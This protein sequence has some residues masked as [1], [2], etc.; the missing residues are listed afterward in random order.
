[1]IS[2]DIVQGRIDQMLSDLQVPFKM[3]IIPPGLH[4]PSPGCKIAIIF[5]VNRQRSK[6]GTGLGLLYVP[7]ESFDKPERSQWIESALGTG[8]A[9]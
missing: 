3:L 6:G 2:E 9:C 5:G 7:S 4:T 1:M 8:E